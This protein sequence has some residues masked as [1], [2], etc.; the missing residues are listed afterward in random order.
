MQHVQYTL[1]YPEITRIFKSRLQKYLAQQ[2]GSIVKI[3]IRKIFG[4][5]FRGKRYTTVHTLFWHY[6][7]SN[8]IIQDSLKRKWILIE[9]G[10]EGK[11]Y[12]YAVYRRLN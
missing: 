5:I 10:V 9:T 4:D 11:K 2:K 8:K 7:Y 3:K 12:R 1:I 6:I